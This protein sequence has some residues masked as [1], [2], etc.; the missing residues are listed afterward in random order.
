M[1]ERKEAMK[2]LREHTSVLADLEATAAKK[3]TGR[4]ANEEA[5]LQA[6]LAQA[7][8][9]V[10][11]AQR[12]LDLCN[13]NLRQAPAPEPRPGTS[14]TDTCFSSSFLPWLTHSFPFHASR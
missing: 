10:Q 11:L 12:S 13:D 14:P 9:R 2:A 1:A 8:S 6:Q 5:E 3:N 7:R 4:T